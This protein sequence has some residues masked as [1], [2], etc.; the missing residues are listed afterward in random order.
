MEEF[1]IYLVVEAQKVQEDLVA[2]ETVEVTHLL[3]PQMLHQEQ[4]TLEVVVVEQVLE[5]VEQ[6]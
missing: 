4:L 5:T 3:L 2:V 1:I 6:V